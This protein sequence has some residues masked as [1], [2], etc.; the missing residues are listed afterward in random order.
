MTT[1]PRIR[2]IS[3]CIIGMGGLGCPASLALAAD[4]VSK[5]TLIDP[6]TVDETNWH[7][8][9]WFND[10]DFGQP[11][12]ERAAL[13]LKARFPHLQITPRVEAVTV[14]NVQALLKQH[15]IAIDGTDDTRIKFLLSDAA[16]VTGTPLVFGGVI[17]LEGLTFRIR[18]SGPCLRCLF[19]VP[20]AETLS[21]A[22][23]GVM[24]SVAGFI[25]ALQGELALSPLEVIGKATLH[26]FNGTTL[27][28]RRVSI[29]RA[30]DCPACDGQPDT[31]WNAWRA[32]DDAWQ[33]RPKPLPS[34]ATP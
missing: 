8:Q 19:E 32:G 26:R 5:L 7:R 9:S 2:P 13:R 1:P 12:A 18:P 20:D 14:D 15:T 16:V 11:K 33:M 27:R 31:L 29:A 30:P 34:L 21:C 10:E 25:G 22:F 3:A 17:R 24:G 4:G 6:D 28:H 23:A